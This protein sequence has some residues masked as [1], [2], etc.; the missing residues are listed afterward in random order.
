MHRLVRIDISGCVQLT[1]SGMA[2]IG[3]PKNAYVRHV[4]TICIG[5]C[6]A[7]THEGVLAL[8]EHCHHVGLDGLEGCPRQLITDPVLRQI[9]LNQRGTKALDLQDC[10][11]ISDDGLAHLSKACR[12]LGSLGLGGCT[13]IT[14]KGLEELVLRFTSGVQNPQNNSEVKE[15]WQRLTIRHCVFGI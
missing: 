2:T 9:A 7:L 4:H 3:D 14:S 10:T 13:S 6:P 8:L 15:I 5:R 11:E 1:D 12:V